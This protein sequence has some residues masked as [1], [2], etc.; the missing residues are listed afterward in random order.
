MIIQ[1]NRP[2]VSNNNINNVVATNIVAGTYKITVNALNV[3]QEPS[4]I[5]PMLTRLYKDELIELSNY[6][7]VADGYIWGRYKD[8]YGRYNYLAVR[9]TNGKEF[10]ALSE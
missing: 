7:K 2:L 9:S 8:N 10:A 4:K 6:S 1:N 5:A 3:R